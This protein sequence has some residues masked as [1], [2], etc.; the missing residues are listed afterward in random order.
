MSESAICRSCGTEIAVAASGVLCAT[1]VG[2]AR[3]D[4]LRARSIINA[5][6]VGLVEQIGVDPRVV[7]MALLAEAAEGARSALGRRSDK[8]P[9][10][11]EDFLRAARLAWAAAEGN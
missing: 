8:G 6:S 10:H 11:A 5:V 7:F 3:D 9:L 2:P 1:C 4:Y